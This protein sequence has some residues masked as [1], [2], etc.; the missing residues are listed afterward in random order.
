MLQDF[1]REW[2]NC[3]GRRGPRAGRLIRRE[4]LQNLIAELHDL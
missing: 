2:E 1:R 3:A 4:A